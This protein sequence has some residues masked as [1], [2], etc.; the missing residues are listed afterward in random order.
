MPARKPTS[1]Q[2][3]SLLAPLRWTLWWRRLRT[4]CSGRS[5]FLTAALE[6]K[7]IVTSKRM[8]QMVVKD[9]LYR[10]KLPLISLFLSSKQVCWIV[11]REAEQ[12]EP[13]RQAT[14]VQIEYLKWSELLIFFMMLQVPQRVL[15]RHGVAD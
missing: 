14:R 1:T 12:V 10:N 6:A 9:R 7:Q 3:N 8:V 11:P 13:M 2:I 15:Q 4:K 5:E